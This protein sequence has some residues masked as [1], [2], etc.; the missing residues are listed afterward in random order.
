MKDL[1]L[2]KLKT[3]NKFTTCILLIRSKAEEQFLLPE[4][5]G[6]FVNNSAALVASL[7]RTIRYQMGHFL[8]NGSF[9]T[10]S[11]VVHDGVDL[12]SGK[13]VTMTM[14]KGNLM[15]PAWA[16]DFASSSYRQSVSYLHTLVLKRMVD[17][18]V[19]W[20]REIN[21]FDYRAPVAC[22]FPRHDD[23]FT[24]FRALPRRFNT[25]RGDDAHIEREKKQL[26]EEENSGRKRRS[27]PR[28]FCRGNSDRPL[29]LRSPINWRVYYTLTYSFSWKLPH[30]FSCYLIW[31]PYWMQ[32][33]GWKVSKFLIISS[34]IIFEI[35]LF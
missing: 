13:S 27:G 34:L 1:L 33:W 23:W 17:H 8:L 31:E 6:S 10:S 26:K 24:R 19:R 25:E 30:F 7:F 32:K 14:S 22:S 28:F 16:F 11:R 12:G 5:A 2:V 29:I 15:S 20:L 21:C 9:T 4:A 3:D 35:L 18:S